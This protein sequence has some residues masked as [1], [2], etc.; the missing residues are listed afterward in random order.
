MNRACRALEAVIAAMLAVMVVLVFGNVVLRYGFNSGIT[1]SEEVSRWLFIWM[2]FLGAIVALREH[3]HLGVDMVVHGAREL[4]LRIEQVLQPAGLEHAVAERPRG[5][6]Q[7]VA[8]LHAS[9]VLGPACMDACQECAVQAAHAFQVRWAHVAWVDEDWV[10]T[11]RSL[12]IKG[13]AGAP[14]DGL[15]RDESVSAHV[16]AEGG[17]VVVPHVQRDPRFAHHPMLLAHGIRFFAAVPLADRKSHIL[18]ALVIFDDQPRQLD[19]RETELLQ[20][21]AAR[22]MQALLQADG[23]APA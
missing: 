19:E 6:A 23:A 11:P 2:T 3:G 20:N 5:D 1:V 9:G 14:L 21:M 8:A 10:H 17:M 18:G 4:A 7:R 22:L 13:S 16:V 15:P 12:L